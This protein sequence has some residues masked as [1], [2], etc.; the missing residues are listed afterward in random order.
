MEVLIKK[1][2][3]SYVEKEW[4][5]DAKVSLQWLNMQSMRV[6]Q[7]HQVWKFIPNDVRTIKRA[8]H[9]TQT[10]YRNIHSAGKQAQ[11]RWALIP[12]MLFAL[13]GGECHGYTLYCR[14]V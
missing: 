1:Q 12:G 13:W 7:V 4:A 14:V 8:Y 10:T 11:I 6:G 5:S 2:I 9:K 3:D